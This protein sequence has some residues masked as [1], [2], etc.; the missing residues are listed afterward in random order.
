MYRKI[1]IFLEEW[2]KSEHR[3]PLILQ[4]A[5]QVGKT[6]I[7]KKFGRE[8]FRKMVYISMAEPSGKKF[9]HCLSVASEWEIGQPVDENPIRKALEMYDEGFVDDKDTVIIID[10]IFCVT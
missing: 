1:M 9:L 10:E 5:R 6:Y 4:G 8:N 3:K 7:L 2:K